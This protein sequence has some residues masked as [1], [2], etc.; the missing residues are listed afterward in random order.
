MI[1]DCYIPDGRGLNDYG[2]ALWWTAMLMTTM[3][4]EYWPQTPEGR[5]LCFILSLYAFTVFG[6]VTAVL[7]TFFVG[8]DAED[9]E[10]ELAGAESI[11]ALHEQI[12][13][14][15]SE[16]QALSRQ[17]SEVNDS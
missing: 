8:R 3:G 16:I 13:A 4:S 6:Y 5:I 7:A 15:R 9:E 10:A 14:L 12:K 17:N 11:D 1:P 2:T